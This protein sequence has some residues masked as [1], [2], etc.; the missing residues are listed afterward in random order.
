MNIS[1]SDGLSL[2][3]DGKNLQAIEF[4]DD[5]EV[6]F[7]LSVCLLTLLSAILIK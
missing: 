1:D 6:M 4:S 3:N 5:H 7:R 2:S